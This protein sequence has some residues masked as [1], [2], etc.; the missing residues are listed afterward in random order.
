MRLVKGLQRQN[1]AI[2]VACPPRGPLAKAVDQAAVERVSI[3]SF[4]ASLRLDPIQTSTSMLR[5]AAGRGALARAARRFD[6]DI[7]HA[8][9]PRA[10]LIGAV[11]RRLGG[12]RSWSGPTSTCPRR[13]SGAACAPCS[14]TR[15]ARSSACRGRWAQLQ[16]RARAAAGHPRLQQ[17]RQRR[18]DPAGSKQPAS[19]RLGIAPEAAM[20]GHIAQ[21]TPWKAQDD[22]I[23]ALALLNGRGQRA[24]A[25]GRQDRRSPARACASTTAPTSKA[26][27]RS[28]PSSG[29]RTG[30]HF[31]GQ[32]P[33][34]PG[35]PAGARPLA[36]A[37]L[38]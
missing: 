21:I 13:R 26:F 9:T 5:L 19:E 10:G 30:F 36:A 2:A 23:R 27:T 1:T 35:D 17:L 22:S 3:P 8:N 15:R 11:A 24:P 28:S 16:R 14:R 31:L 29:S 4:E 12:R 20:L 37:L 18:F 38:G 32:R 33:R 34:C 7:I 6:A 25:R